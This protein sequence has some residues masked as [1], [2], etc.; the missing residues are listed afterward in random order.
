MKRISAVLLAAVLT[1]G[2][3]TGCSGKNDGGKSTGGKIEGKVTIVTANDT[4]G[5]VKHMLEAFQKEYPDVEV[6]HQML[7][8]A[9]DDVKKSL[10]TSFAAGD[11]DPDVIAC[12]IIWVSQFAA[13][14]WLLD[15][16][17]ELEAVKDEYLGGPLKTCYYDGKAYA[18]PDYTDVGLM[19]YRN[20]LVDHAPATWDELQSM[21][22]E[23]QGKDGIDYGFVFQMF[24]GEP[25][26]C[27]MLEFIK[28][29]GGH[30]LLNG[31]FSMANENT[32][33]A[34]DFVK[35]LI[36][37][38]I[39]PE[40]VLGW[41]PDDSLSVFSEGKALFMRNWTYAYA[42]TQ[43][44]ESKVQ[45]KVGVAALPVGPNGSE[46][47]GTLGGWNLAVNKNTDNKDAAVALAKFMTSYEAQKIATTERSTFPTNKKVYEDKEVLEA[48]P[49]LTSV[50]SAADKAA[51]RPQVRDYPTVSTII[52]EYMHKV[53]AGGEPNDQTMQAMDQALNEALEKMK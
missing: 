17:T 51:P 42:R 5:A 41:R 38:G 53:L 39:S 16:T 14:D 36:S 4:T 50:R 9:S 15:V 6:E 25:T 19:Y 7:P 29:N 46:S 44:D 43:L 40:D 45:G 35:G 52:Q 21:C 26:P 37:D 20:D 13:A 8:G 28:Q 23:H 12:D 24:Q 33:E 48:L 34:L 3:L 2:L 22:R 30:D 31:R 11:T 10:M 27:N 1:L 49:Y 32:Y 47:S 18:F